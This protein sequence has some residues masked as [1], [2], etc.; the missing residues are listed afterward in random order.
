[1]RIY[2]D[3]NILTKLDDHPELKRILD[4]Y[5]EY[6]NIVYSEAHIDD[7]SRSGNQEKTIDDLIKIRE[8][9]HGQCMAKYLKQQHVTYEKRDP[10]EF[11][12]T[13]LETSFSP[14]NLDGLDQSF[15]GIDFAALGMQ[16]PVE[17]L[18]L[19][20]ATFKET[21]LDNLSSPEYD[22]SSLFKQ[23]G[24]QPSLK[25]LIADMMNL[26]NG[27]PESK[28]F[29]KHARTLMDEHVEQRKSLSNQTDPIAYLNSILPG[30]AMGRSFEDFNEMAMEIGKTNFTDQGEKERFVTSYSNLDLMGF[31]ADSKMSVQNINTDATHAYF[32]GHCE[33]FITQDQKLSAKADAVYDEFGSHTIIMDVEKAVKLIPELIPLTNTAEDLI[34]EIGTHS[35]TS[36]VECHCE[37][38]TRITST[39]SY[40]DKFMLGFF[41]EYL[42]HTYPEGGFLCVYYK[43][44]PTFSKWF[45]RREYELLTNK[46]VAILGH[47]NYGNGQFGDWTSEFQGEQQLWRGR[48]WG[49][50]F[51]IVLKQTEEFGISLFIN[52][53]SIPEEQNS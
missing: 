12:E 20:M 24:Q 16:D 23:S 46:I 4:Q 18:N 22:Y 53:S 44:I 3:T 17:A 27:S 15:A 21:V 51:Q 36:V 48:Y 39:V 13:T 52:S 40:L 42:E 10:V 50:T 37:V 45:Y 28:A 14:A 47:D 19:A 2:L 26:V 6:L 25:S 11:Y 33:L 9:T 34:A 41:D 31:R 35:Q 32:A 8:L 5:S 30:S 1:M 49:N 43:S 7:L 29:Y 38:A